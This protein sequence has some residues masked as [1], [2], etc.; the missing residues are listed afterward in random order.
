[1]S[2]TDRR[3][4]RL[5]AHL[6]QAE[7]TDEKLSFIEMGAGNQLKLDETEKTEWSVRCELAAAYR[8]ADH[9]GWMEVR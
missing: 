8:L 6:V 2:R 1:M 9:Y 5:S 4:S 7:A 3:V